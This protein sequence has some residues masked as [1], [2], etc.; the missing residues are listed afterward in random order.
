MKRALALFIAVLVSG[1]AT[2]AVRERP[3]LTTTDTASKAT[4]CPA[5]ELALLVDDDGW[6]AAGCGQVSSGKSPAVA[7]QTEPLTCASLSRFDVRLRTQLAK[8]AGTPLLAPVK[9]SCRE[10]NVATA[11]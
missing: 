3:L 1:C 5:D 9:G 4:G 10:T 8:K 6:M 11:R 7:E 2:V